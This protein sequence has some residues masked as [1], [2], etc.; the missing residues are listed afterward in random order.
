[1]HIL[2]DILDLSKTEAGRITIEE[3]DFSVAD[4]VRAA[5]TLWGAQARSKGLAFASASASASADGPSIVRGDASRI[6]QVLHNLVSNAVKFT[7]AGQVTVSA[8]VE[9]GDGTGLTLRFTVEDT[10]IGME[11]G[12]VDRV[13]R[14]FLQ[15]D[16]STTRRFTGLGLAISE[17]LVTLLGGRIGVDSRPGDGSTFWFTVPVGHCAAAGP[18]PAAPPERA[19]AT[20]A[21]EARGRRLLVAEDNLVNQK[22]VGLLLAPLGCHIDYAAN[23]EEAVAAATA[24]RYDIILMDLQMPL[25]D[26][27]EAMRAIR[28]LPDP[29]LASTPIIALTANAMKGERDHH[30]AQ[31]MDDYLTKPIDPETLLKVVG[32]WL[33]PKRPAAT[34]RAA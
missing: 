32:G 19:M 6:R 3:S 24:T 22:L 11:R 9:Q 33:R 13:F 14:P 23:G 20:Q 30:L 10:G 16:G 12:Q 5:E 8:A 28:A 7:D 4:L 27:V 1:M 25:I 31:G 34:V 18:A 17:K 21:S 15:A 2:N 26:G 29:V